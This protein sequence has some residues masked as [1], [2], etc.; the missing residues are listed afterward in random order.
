MTHLGGGL[1]PPWTEY[2][3][4]HLWKK[5][6]GKQKKRLEIQ[7]RV[8]NFLML[9]S[10][11]RNPVVKGFSKAWYLSTAIAVRVSDETNIGKLKRGESWQTNL[12]NPSF[13]Y[14]SWYTAETT[15]GNCKMLMTSLTAKFA[16]RKLVVVCISCVLCTILITNTFPINPVTKNGIETK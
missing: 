13:T 7:M 9:C 14:P 12:L 1:A 11:S 2:A 6:N 15:K 5:N 8:M 3:W 4:L 10:W 16:K